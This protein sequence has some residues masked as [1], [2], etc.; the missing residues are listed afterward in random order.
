MALIIVLIAL[1]IQRFVK[2]NSYSRQFD[3]AAHYFQWMSNRIK[4]ITTGHGLIGLLILVV[5]VV[6][7]TAIIFSLVYQLLGYLGAG[8]LQLA[9]VWYCLDGRDIRKEPYGDATTEKILLQTYQH[10]FAVLFWY[11][12]LGPVGLVLYICVSQLSQVAPRT[13]ASSEQETQHNG[14]HLYEY[15]SKTLGILDWVPVRLL[16]LS[17][18]LVGSFAAVFKLWMR[19]LFEGITDPPLLVVEW[20]QAALAAEST[21]K[22]PLES[23][24]DLVDRSLLVWLFVVLLVTVGVFLG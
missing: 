12:V 11:C 2:F 9:L 20:G 17:F 16:G 6:L 15:L 18:A 10:L 24:I 19:K 23:T 3:W 21:E 8:V 13:L 4:Q 22:S 7:V 1:A 5:P 14:D